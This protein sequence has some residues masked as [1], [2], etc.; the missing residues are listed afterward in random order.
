MFVAA[1][2]RMTWLLLIFENV[3]PGPSGYNSP[4]NSVRFK[5]T[6]PAQGLVALGSF[7]EAVRERRSGT[8]SGCNV[9]T[10]RF[11]TL[12]NFDQ[13]A[14]INRRLR[15]HDA[16]GMARRVRPCPY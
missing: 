7:E 13:L 4:S 1:R 5:E 3:K 14:E 2:V 8:A 10:S 6:T 9:N 12:F 11:L 15:R 16:A